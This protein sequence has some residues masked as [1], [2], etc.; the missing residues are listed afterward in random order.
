MMLRSTN[1][2]WTEPKLKPQG[3]ESMFRGV[4]AYVESRLDKDTEV[5]IAQLGPACDGINALN[6]LSDVECC[7]TECPPSSGPFVL[8]DREHGIPTLISSAVSRPFA[9]VSGAPNVVMSTLS[10]P[11]LAGRFFVGVDGAL[12]E[13]RNGGYHHG[14]AIMR[15]PNGTVIDAA[16]LGSQVEAF[17]EGDVALSFGM[18]AS[19]VDPHTSHTARSWDGSA[20]GALV[21]IGGPMMLREETPGVWKHWSTGTSPHFCLQLDRSGL[22]SPAGGM[23]AHDDFPI[24]SAGYTA[25]RD[26]RHVGWRGSSASAEAG[27]RPATFAVASIEGYS[28]SSLLHG[29]ARDVIDYEIRLYFRDPVTFAVLA[30]KRLTD[31]EAYAATF[32]DRTVC[33]VGALPYRAGVQVRRAED[34]TWVVSVID[35]ARA[36]VYELVRYASIVGGVMTFR[37]SI[38]LLER[39]V[40]TAP[41]SGALRVVYL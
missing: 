32:T 15:Q 4:V 10:S 24:T 2:K 39:V 25:E 37:Y 21:G 5:E 23:P 31:V 9:G 26:I 8:A 30:W 34:G 40:L 33:S 7:T 18:Y 6:F 28:A 22:S 27:Y 11:P 17:I 12:F 38:V 20:W 16:P 14:R 41:H 36:W 3:V 13:G 1:S 19:E 35:G 29:V